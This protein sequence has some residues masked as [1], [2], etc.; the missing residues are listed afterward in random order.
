LLH[1]SISTGYNIAYFNDKVYRTNGPIIVNYR[2]NKGIRRRT[3]D[4]GRK[5]EDYRLLTTLRTAWNPSLPGTLHD[6][7][8]VESAFAEATADMPVQEMRILD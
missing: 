1:L 6:A 2:A 5:T 8:G 3:E 4:G 7:D